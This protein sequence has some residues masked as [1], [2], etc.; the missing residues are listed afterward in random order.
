[1]KQF[2][3]SLLA[4]F[5]FVVSGHS[6]QGQESEPYPFAVIGD[7]GCDCAGQQEVALR[8][9]EWYKEHPFDVVL[10]VGDNI[11]GTTF[12][13]MHGRMGGDK[14]LFA[15]RF[16]KHY[17]PLIDK[18]VKFYAALGNHDLLTRKGT[19]VINDKQRFNILSEKGYY[20][21]SPEG[22]EK[23]VTFIALDS[24]DLVENRVDVEQ[25]DWF[26]KV[27][28]ESKS[29]W[30][31]V[32]MHHP[33]YSPSG[34]HT[35]DVELRKKLEPLFIQAGIQIVLTG[36][37][38]FYARM[39]PQSG[40]YHFVTGGGGNKLKSPDRDPLADIALRTFQFM[41]F[42]LSPDQAQFW[43]IPPSGKPVD[44]GT[45]QLQKP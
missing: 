14:D 30:K 17:K 9:L 42:E 16:D 44:Q 37:N 5:L 35:T 13:F 12:G 15:K 29:I 22:K 1:M 3:V 31:I 27:A 23:L 28:G 24:T 41:Y 39:K 2:F 36:H 18:G 8:M 32:Y 43:S 40:I 45:I 7:M 38:H 26:Q 4:A 19:D 25:T 33:I 20:A 10:T 34:P 6:A 11:Y 21:F